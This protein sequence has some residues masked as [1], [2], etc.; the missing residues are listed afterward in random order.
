MERLADMY[1]KE[2]RR[3]LASELQIANLLAVPRVVKV[4]VNVGLNQ[5]RSD[6]KKVSEISRVVARIT[7]Q[8][9]SLRR[10][11]K[12]ISSFKLR[13]G[14]PVGLALTLR[15]KRMYDFI[16]RLTRIAL[17]RVRDFRGIRSASLDA[18]GNLTLGI[19]ELSVF[20]EIGYD[21]SGVVSGLEVTIV[22]TA[23]DTASGAKLLKALGVPLAVN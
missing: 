16:E 20:P 6:A 7:G 17:P 13:A 19:R 11:R 12:S 1:I 9:P 2:I 22:T 23:H 8:K 3:Q 15:G 14:E 5:A 21:D 10:A 18:Q 4:T